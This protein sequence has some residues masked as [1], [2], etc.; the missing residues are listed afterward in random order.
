[1][2]QLLQHLRKSEICVA[3]VIVFVVLYMCGFFSHLSPHQVSVCNHSFA[4]GNS[5]RTNELLAYLVYCRLALY[6]SGLDMSPC[7]LPCLAN[8]FPTCKQISHTY[9]TR[10]TALN[11][12]A[13]LLFTHTS[14]STDGIAL[15]IKPVKK[16]T[17][18]IM[19]SM[20]KYVGCVTAGSWQT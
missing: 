6:L 15:N 10:S 13:V 16:A 5:W 9:P 3:N 11:P 19:D 1:M 18:K 4:Y 8:N 20:M 17:S 2:Y 12:T 7:C 14:T